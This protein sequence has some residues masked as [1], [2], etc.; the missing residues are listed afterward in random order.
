MNLVLNKWRKDE[1]VIRIGYVVLVGVLLLPLV[2]AIGVTSYIRLGA[3]AAAL[4]NSVIKIAPAQ[5]RVVVNIGWLTTGVGR[6]VAG[7]FPLDPEVHLAISSIRAAEVGVYRLEQPL[8]HLDRAQVLA[9]TESTMR[10]RGWERI[11]GVSQEKRLV[12][13]FMPQRAS[14]S[15]LRCCVLVV[16]DEDL[17]VVGARGNIEGV[18]RL[19]REKLDCSR[20]A[21]CPV[22]AAR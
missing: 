22:L 4:K 12:A 5:T 21:L 7:F 13:V 9:E 1:G 2:G 17:V 15:N 20:Q 18:L 6:L 11:V 10:K 16:S 14:G 3:D 19:V 8:K